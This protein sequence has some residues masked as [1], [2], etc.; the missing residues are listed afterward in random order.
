MDTKKYLQLL[1]YMKFVF[2]VLLMISLRA[3]AQEKWDLSPDEFEQSIQKENVQLL[4]VR[5]AGEYQA[6]HISH[7]LQADWHNLTQ[8]KDRV[9]H[10]NKEK[11]VYVY[12][13]A[14]PRSTAA[15]KWLR[16]NG[17]KTVYELKGGFIKWK[18]ANKPVAEAEKG[19]TQLTMDDYQA[20]IK[21]SPVILVDFGA[22]WCP[23]CRNMEPILVQLQKD[24]PGKFKLIKVDAGIH[25][26]LLKQMNAEDIPTFIV[27]KNGKEVW[28]EHGIVA[29]ETLKKAIGN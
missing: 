6:G 25:T 27:Y 20:M 9:Q 26:E 5:T 17:Y 22:E 10:I 2:P 7:S 18:S 19:V 16:D 4:D 15:A 1:P 13:A 3:S 14:G 8:F 29:M 11:A 21:T 28:R 24:L 12:C 23:P